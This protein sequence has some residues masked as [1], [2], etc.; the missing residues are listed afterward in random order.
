LTT[1]DPGRTVEVVM[2]RADT[3]SILAFPIARSRAR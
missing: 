2:A 1:S 3:L